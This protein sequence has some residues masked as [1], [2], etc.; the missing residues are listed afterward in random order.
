MPSPH[1]DIGSPP[2]FGMGS[3]I[4]K[5]GSHPPGK[6]S[7]F[8]EGKVSSRMSVVGSYHRTA[9]R[10][11]LDAG[12]I[13]I[14]RSRDP[15]NPFTGVSTISPTSH[16]RAVSHVFQTARLRLTRNHLNATDIEVRLGAKDNKHVRV[17]MG[18]RDAPTLNGREN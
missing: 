17:L 2:V 7:V 4:L 14:D 9:T 8:G 15:P 5:H 6:I 16:Y 3:K 11:R 1:R 13:N 18:P 12:F 10:S